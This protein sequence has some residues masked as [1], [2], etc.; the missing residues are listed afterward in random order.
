M[1]QEAF[2]VL[3]TQELA[4]NLNNHLTVVRSSVQIYQLIL[5]FSVDIVSFGMQTRLKNLDALNSL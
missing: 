3:V 5:M 2:H 4:L 1:L